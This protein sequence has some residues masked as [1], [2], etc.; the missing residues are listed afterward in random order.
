MTQKT[1]NVRT[2]K[3]LTN[4][5]TLVVGFHYD[6]GR[7]NSTHKYYSAAGN[8]ISLNDYNN[9]NKI[10]SCVAQGCDYVFNLLL[11]STVNTRTLAV[12]VTYGGAP[13]LNELIEID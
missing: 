10:D 5:F 4:K 13:G 6:N 11:T 1:D 9:N 3:D 2:S 8:H 12:N 7:S